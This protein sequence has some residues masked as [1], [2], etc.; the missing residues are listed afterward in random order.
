MKILHC[1]IDNFGTLSDK[2]YD[3]DSRLTSFCRENGEGKTTLAAFLKAMFYGL[4]KDGKNYGFN[5]R[6][7]YVPF[8]NGKFGGSLKVEKDGKIYTITRIFD[9]KSETKDTVKLYIG[10]DEQDLPENIGVFFLGMNKESF[11][12]TVFINAEDI[13]IS[14]T[15]DISAKLSGY[16]DDTD[17]GVDYDKAVKVLDD[18]RKSIKRDRKTQNAELPK[19]ERKINNVEEEISNEKQNCADIE[20]YYVNRNNL[21][22]EIQEN[23][24]ELSRLNEL[25]VVIGYWDQYD[26]FLEDI[27]NTDNDLS[28]IKKKYPKGLPEKDEIDK[29]NEATQNITNL[30]TQ[31]DL[32]C[33]K[34]DTELEKLEKVFK[35]GIPSEKELSEA[36]KV[37]D[38]MNTMSAKINTY[39]EKSYTPHQQEIIKRFSD[40][41]PDDVLIAKADEYISEITKKRRELD[42]LSEQI[43]TQ[44][45]TG[46]SLLFAIVG[47]IAG[48]IAALFWNAIVG[49]VIIL[50]NLVL[51]GIVLLKNVN[52]S[53]NSVRKATLKAEIGGYED[54]VNEIL[55]PYGYFSKSGVTATL[56]EFKKEY[57]EYKDLVSQNIANEQAI[58]NMKNQYNGLKNKIDDFIN[59]YNNEFK[60]IAALK[61][62]IS[63]FQTL[64]TSK[65]KCEDRCNELQNKLSDNRKV[66]NTI[67]EKYSIDDKK[68]NFI[69]ELQEDRNSFNI[70]TKTKSDAL[71]KAKK[72]KD[73]KGLQTRPTESADKL[74]VDE[75]NEKISANRQH[76]AGIEE[77]IRQ[78]EESQQRIDEKN[79]ELKNLNDKYEEL[80]EK[81]RI[82]SATTSFLTQAEQQLRDKYVAPVE[83]TCRKY[84]SQLENALGERV[85]MNKEYSIY[86]E[87][88]GENREINHLSNGQRTL[89][90]L[91][92]R[93]ALTDNMFPNNRPF[94]IL[95]DPFSGLDKNHME[96]A[97]ELVKELSDDRQIIYFCAHESRII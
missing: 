35:K 83:N 8:N 96:K 4:P 6:R 61:Q 82:I 47:I 37:Y 18:K 50:I 1:D 53:D 45:Y 81:H 31:L 44:S 77:T 16:V 67:I 76:L 36:E 73:E 91:C 10:A 93:L 88:D 54:S 49:I 51:I 34:D 58:N 65:Q 32:S 41:E 94:L 55:V 7:H 27:K 15:S 2:H 79:A 89:A 92:F 63:K 11:E 21:A 20:N 9:R 97:S 30:N 60:D 29:L 78:K 87:K 74:T 90:A 5:D 52:K 25:R 43:E 14:T 66:L 39:E 19:L 86:F 56:S 40:K 64:T 22:N 24:K 33:F 95:D 72:Y 46:F 85:V 28:N 80:S 48:C 38:E 26:T 71:E 59:L 84:I 69:N 75:L 70:Y 68:E 3:F 12:R 23:E 42:E 62:G 13:D 57:E 17:T